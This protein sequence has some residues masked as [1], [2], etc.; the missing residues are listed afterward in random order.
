MNL[1]GMFQAHVLLFLALFRASLALGPRGR[2]DGVVSCSVML[3]SC[4]QRGLMRLKYRTED[5]IGAFTDYD[6]P[7]T[8]QLQKCE[9]CDCHSA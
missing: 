5:L 7:C 1:V 4:S 9:T 3:H 8:P 2:A 6:T